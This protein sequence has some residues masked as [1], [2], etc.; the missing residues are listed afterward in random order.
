MSNMSA[1]MIGLAVIGGVVGFLTGGVGFALVG[2]TIGLGIG[3]YVDPVTPDVP[4]VGQPAT[5]EVELPTATE[6]L[7][8]PEVLGTQPLY[9][10]IFWYGLERSEEVKEKVGKGGSKKVTVGYKYY[11][12]WATGLCLGPCDE[13]LSIWTGDDVLWTGPL[14]RPATV[15]GSVSSE[16]AI[17]DFGTITFNWGTTANKNIDKMVSAINDQFGTSYTNYNL[18]NFVWVYFDDCLL[19]GANRVPA[20]KFIVRRCPEHDFN[21][22]KRIGLYD[23]NPVH[24]M[25]HIFTQAN[26]AGLGTTFIDNDSFSDAATEMAKAREQRGVSLTFNRQNSSLEYLSALVQHIGVVLRFANSGKFVIKML[27]NYEAKASLPEITDEDLIKPAVIRRSQ[28]IEAVNDVKVIYSERVNVEIVGYPDFYSFIFMDEATGPDYN[29]NWGYAIVGSENPMANWDEDYPLLQAERTYLREDAVHKIFLIHVRESGGGFDGVLWPN[30]VTE[31]TLRNYDV[32]YDDIVYNYRNIDTVRDL[33]LGQIP[34]H[35]Y[36][37]GSWFS[38][39]Y[40]TSASMTSAQI[41][42]A[43]WMIDNMKAYLDANNYEYNTIQVPQP[44]GYER[45]IEWALND[46]ND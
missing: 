21:S 32:W 42:T 33:F 8:I 19:G 17:D 25:Y 31:L 45:W 20:I 26:L 2:A 38:F 41:D 11:L 14:S 37:P 4:G 36:I 46:L 29:D 10:N 24:A 28:W 40:D 6:G 12:S 15:S 39:S 16:I 3:S 44:S 7:L 1:G 9:G 23:Y 35:G 27:R 5:G 30:T 22:A 43:E 34:D 13:L 18:N